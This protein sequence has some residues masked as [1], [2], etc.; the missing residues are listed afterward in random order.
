MFI[1]KGTP[2]EASFYVFHKDKHCKIYATM[3]EILPHWAKLRYM[4]YFEILL[5]LSESKTVFSL[6]HV[7]G[8]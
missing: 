8:P 5:H 7:L 2:L 6:G 4:G 3:T 1:I